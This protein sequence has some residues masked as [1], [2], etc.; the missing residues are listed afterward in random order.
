MVNQKNKM[1]SFRLS[2]EEYSRM[3]EHCALIG[4]Q[5]LSEMARVAMQRLIEAQNADG[6]TIYVQVRHL[7]SKIQDLSS[8]VERISHIVEQTNGHNA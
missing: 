8:E 1:V 6:E 3:R 2:D 5:S 7:R 4:V